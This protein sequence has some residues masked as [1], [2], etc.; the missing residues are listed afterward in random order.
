VLLA[1]KYSIKILGFGGFVDIPDMPVETSLS[2]T[3]MPSNRGGMFAMDLQLES[4]S[5][6]EMKHVNLRNVLEKLQCR[7]WKN[8]TEYNVVYTIMGL[9]ADMSHVLVNHLI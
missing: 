8:P 1:R 7:F 9:A 2:G 3:L 6:L 4:Q 5:R